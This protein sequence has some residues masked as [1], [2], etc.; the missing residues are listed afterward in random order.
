MLSWSKSMAR[1]KVIVMCGMAAST[2]VALIVFVAVPVATGTWSVASIAP[3][4]ALAIVVVFLSV[5]AFKLEK[6]RRALGE[7][8]A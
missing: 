1:L 3:A 4:A 5:L 7:L 6:K 2:A 8:A